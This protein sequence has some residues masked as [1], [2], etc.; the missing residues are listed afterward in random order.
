MKLNRYWPVT[1][2]YDLKTQL[3]IVTKTGESVGYQV[4]FDDA[5]LTFEDDLT[6]LKGPNINL[7]IQS[8]VFRII[9]FFN[10]IF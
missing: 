9:Y 2:N 8:I 4:S 10:N 5:P 3:Y 7:N 1:L 6:Y